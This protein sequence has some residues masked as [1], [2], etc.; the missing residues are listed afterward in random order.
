MANPLIIRGQTFKGAVS[1][2]QDDGCNPQN[3][4]PY[5]LAAT[6]VI[7]V[8]FPQD[9]DLAIPVP[10]ILSTTNVGEITIVSLPLGQFTYVGAPAKSLLLGI[11][12]NLSIDIKVTHLDTT[13]DIFEEVKTI[14][15]KDADN[16]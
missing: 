5:V 1:L 2:K 11:G 3:V 12:K 14:D 13:V 4:F 6:D 9:K 7:E 15:V 10:V 8:H 16:L